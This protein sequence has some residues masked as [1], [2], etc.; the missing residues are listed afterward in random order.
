LGVRVGSSRSS[1]VCLAVSFC[2]LPK[3]SANKFLRD[4]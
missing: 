3:I 2:N 4:Q 1:G